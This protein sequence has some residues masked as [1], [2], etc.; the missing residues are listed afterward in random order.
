MAAAKLKQYKALR[1][2][3]L[4]Q[5]D[6]LKI[7]ADRAAA[8]PDDFFVEMQFKMLYKRLSAVQRDFKGHHTNI[9]TTIAIQERRLRR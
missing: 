5:I 7:F 9:L 6:E 8:N 4:N 2:M 3:C 1:Q